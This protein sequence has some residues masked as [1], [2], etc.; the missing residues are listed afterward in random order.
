MPELIVVDKIDGT[1]VA[2]MCSGCRQR[3]S[4]RGKFTTQERQN[5][6]AGEFKLHLEQSHKLDKANEPEDRA[7]GRAYASTAARTG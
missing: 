4:I 6:I 3:F 5:K 7:S 2:W 1:A